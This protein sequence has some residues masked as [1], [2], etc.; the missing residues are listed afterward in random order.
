[1]GE[2]LIYRE[3]DFN[4]LAFFLSGPIWIPLPIG[5][6]RAEDMSTPGWMSI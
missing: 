5:E 4:L 6:V 1:M 3:K 2:E